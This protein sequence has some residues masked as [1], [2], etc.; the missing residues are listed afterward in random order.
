MLPL[1][2]KLVIAALIL[3]AHIAIWYAAR[4]EP[5]NT[6]IG[7]SPAGEPEEEDPGQAR[8]AEAA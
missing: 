8:I 1:W 5:D 3:L 4:D 2:S 6:Y 7:N